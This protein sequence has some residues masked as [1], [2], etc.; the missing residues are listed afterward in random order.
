MP[1]F[2]IFRGFNSKL[3]SDKLY[4]GQLPTQLGTIGS[5]DFSPFLLDLYPSA[6][7]A[8]SLRKLRSDYTGFAIRVRRSSDNAE[9]DIGFTL[10]GDL[11]TTSL[12]SFCGSGNGFV[13]TWYDQSG[14]ARNVTQTTAASQPQIVSSGSILNI[15]SKPSIKYDGSNDILT[16]TAFGFPTNAISMAYVNKT[17]TYNAANIGYTSNG[18]L[19]NINFTG[20]I[21]LD[22]RPDGGG[23]TGLS[24]GLTPTTNQVLQFNVYDKVNMK[25]SANG[26]SFQ[27]TSKPVSSIIYGTQNLEIGDSSS[28]GNVQEFIMWSTDESSNKSGIESN[29][30][31]YYGIY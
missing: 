29:I 25:A 17:N 15:N 3:F 11:D 19:I 4:A 27:T 1:D 30:N 20:R 7:A 16:K 10:T 31:T 8:Y 6:A 18:G 2:G 12:T 23:Y 5:I 13:T 22:G 24:S 21:G 28:N 14:N 26:L 9:Q